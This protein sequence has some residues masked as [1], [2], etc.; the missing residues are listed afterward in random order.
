MLQHYGVT[1]AVILENAKCLYAMSC[2][3]QA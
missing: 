2:P 1:L 3:K